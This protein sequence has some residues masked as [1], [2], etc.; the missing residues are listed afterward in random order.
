MK[1][2]ITAALV[3]GLAQYTAAF[4]CTWNGAGSSYVY[5]E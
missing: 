4:P 2:A 3:L 5:R 1:I